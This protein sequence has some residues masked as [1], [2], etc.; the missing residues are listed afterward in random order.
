MEK[1]GL[2]FDILDDDVLT[3]CDKNEI[4]KGNKTY[5]GYAYYTVTDEKG[6]EYIIKVNNAGEE[7][8]RKLFKAKEVESPETENNDSEVENGSNG[9]TNDKE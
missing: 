6:D 7:I 4:K 1:Q 8:D 9:E 3:N 5:I 2:S